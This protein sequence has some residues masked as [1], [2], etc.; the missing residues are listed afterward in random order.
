M[1]SQRSASG[2][3]ARTARSDRWARC[4]TR[5]QK[6]RPGPVT[7]WAAS[8]GP[9]VHSSPDSGAVSSTRNSASGALSPRTAKAK[10][11][12]RTPMRAMCRSRSVGVRRTPSASATSWPCAQVSMRRAV[13][14]EGTA[15]GGPYQGSRVPWGASA[16]ACHSRSRP[17]RQRS[18]SSAG[19]SAAPSS[20][21]SSTKVSGAA[22]ALSTSAANASGA[23]AASRAARS[24]QA[25]CAIWWATVQPG[26]GV[27]RDHHSWPDSATRRSS[28]SLSLR[29]S[30]STGRASDTERS[31]RGTVV[32]LGAWQRS[33]KQASVLA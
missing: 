4:V 15:I 18:S 32:C 3:S 2:P 11:R 9:Y 17:V 16:R 12:V 25:R 23:V 19:G 22:A 27:A 7:R 21:P 28:S 5:R 33:Q 1:S 31:P 26:A 6:S 8:S 24:V 20:A 13:A 14:M 29:R 30:S 10:S